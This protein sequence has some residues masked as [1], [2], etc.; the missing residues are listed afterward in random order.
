MQ[1]SKDIEPIQCA[2]YWTTEKILIINDLHIG[3]EEAL[4]KRGFL[5]PKFQTQEIIKKAQSI[6]KEVKPKIIILNGDIKHTFGKILQQEWKDIRKLLTYLQQHGKVIIIKGN[7]DPII[8]PIV[9]DMDIA[10]VKEYKV[11]DTLIIHGDKLVKT[12]AKRLI[13]GHEHPAIT[14][15]ENSKYEKY[16]CYLKGKWQRKELIV[17]PSFNPLI[18]GTDILKEQ[19]LSPFLKNLKNFEVF[20]LSK[21]EVFEFGKVKNLN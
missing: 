18:E 13:I 2:L 4:Q 15:R 9:K 11:K 1:I 17:M 16:K 7:H 10:I 5:V 12:N 6:L 20:I 8:Q 19:V 14:V 21:K 3:Y